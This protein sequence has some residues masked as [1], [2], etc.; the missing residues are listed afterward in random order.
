MKNKVLCLLLIAGSM[1]I[2]S[3]GTTSYYSSANYDDGIYY[4]P[5]SESRAEMIAANR[6][7]HNLEQ[8]AEK[9]YI[10][11]DSDG[12]TYVLTDNESYENRLRKFDN[13]TYSFYIDYGNWY[14]P[15]YNPWWGSY[16]YPYYGY[17]YNS[18][19]YGWDNPWYGG[20]YGYYD[21]WY[22]GWGGYYG[23]YH[24]GWYPGYC[25]PGHYHP[26]HGGTYYTDNI[27][28][29]R[30]NEGQ[31]SSYQKRTIGTI[32]R[33]DLNSSYVNNGAYTGRR[34]SNSSAGTTGTIYRRT[35]ANN[36]KAVNINN[37]STSRNNGNSGTY[38]RSSRSSNN[39]S[40][41]TRSSNSSN[42]NNSSNSS[43]NNSSSYNRSSSYSGNS[44]YSGSSSSS[45]GSSRSGNGGT[46]GRR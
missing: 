7:L 1:A 27:V 19:Y 4:R 46:G 2:S 39:N 32:R 42:R 11:A 38:T 36:S 15:W 28:Y 10:V 40:S 43:Y 3:C 35:T 41:Y 30:R 29:G 33:D 6:E 21:P 44:G 23:W 24:P 16:R 12:N 9:S 5:T 8:E 20:Y 25:Y 17:A 37:S 45:S 26:G 13:P 18:W 31:G 22:Y 14:S 34:T